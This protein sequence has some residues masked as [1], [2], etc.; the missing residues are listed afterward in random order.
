MIQVTPSHKNLI[1]DYFY[2]LFKYNS[3]LENNKI[4]IHW[5]TNKPN[6]IQNIQVMIAYVCK[7]EP[8][9]ITAICIVLYCVGQVTGDCVSC[10]KVSVLIML[11]LGILW[12]HF[13]IVEYWYFMDTLC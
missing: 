2:E 3:I 6:M 4:Q 7:L 8:I 13:D 11:N 1:W 12:T 5:G 10:G 9:W